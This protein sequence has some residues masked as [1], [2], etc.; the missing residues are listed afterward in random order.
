MATP[1]ATYYP[2]ARVDLHVRFE[3]FG[4]G[5]VAEARRLES[6]EFIRFETRPQSA[7][8]AR[9]TGSRTAGGVQGGA[10]LANVANELVTITGILPTE[11]TVEDNSFRLANTAVVRFPWKDAPF[12]SLLVRA[13]LVDVFMGAATPEQFA[14]GHAAY[15]AA[16]PA[17]SAKR[18]LRFRGW[19]DRW[20]DQHGDGGDWVEVQARDFSALLLD[21]KVPP[22]TLVPLEGDPTVPGVSGSRSRLDNV[23]RSILH[24]LP[25]VRGMEVRVVGFDP[26][27]LPLLDAVAVSRLVGGVTAKEASAAKRSGQRARRL[28]RVPFEGASYWDVVTDLCVSCGLIPVVRLDVLEVGPPRVLYDAPGR[29]VGE[30][31]GAAFEV[32]SPVTGQRRFSRRMVY[33]ENVAEVTFGRDLGRIKAP[34]VACVAY[35]PTSPD[36]A[37]RVIREV[38]PKVPV[39]TRQSPGGEATVEVKT[40]P[41]PSGFTDPSLLV[42]MAEAIHELMGRNEMTAVIATRDLSSF[43]DDRDRD[44]MKVDGIEADLLSGADL[45]SLRSGDAL[46]LLIA[47]ADLHPDA[48][49]FSDLQEWFVQGGA[50][51]NAQRLVQLGFPA[52][53]AEAIVRLVQRGL[54][55]LFRVRNLRVRFSAQDGVAIEIEAVNFIEV[56]AD[57]A[58]LDRDQARVPATTHDAAVTP[59]TPRRAPGGV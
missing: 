29:A 51:G 17:A 40:I 58:R 22:G 30:G 9:G 48:R 54:P 25:S 1:G 14:A 12:F 27:Q 37:K 26:A 53:A 50:A 39:S 28:K 5:Q 23:V 36:P 45:L 6:H 4:E 47:P 42:R 20:N 33:G 7:Q 59:A 2:W 46:E 44:R 18:Y 35:D 24:S 55:T 11:V 57:A 41:M 15:V 16:I 3:D 19:V 10:P 52:Q 8:P 43:V 49:R 38:Y 32:S 56:R 21:A 13:A 31:Q 34:Y